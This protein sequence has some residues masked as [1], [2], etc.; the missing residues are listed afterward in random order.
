M[1]IINQ[2]FRT[3][4]SYLQED[5]YYI[6]EYQREYSWEKSEIEDF[7]IDLIHLYD[8]NITDHFLGQIVIHLDKEEKRKYLIDGQQR[9]ATLTIMLSVFREMFSEIYEKYGIEDAKIDADDITTQYIGR[10]TSRRNELK[11][12]LGESDKR[13]FEKFIQ[14]TEKYDD[15]TN[16]QLTKSEKRVHDAYS[17]FTKYLEQYIENITNAEQRYEVLNNLFHTLIKGFKIMYVE[18]DELN[19]AFIIFETLNAR[20]K[21][22]ETADLLK[23]NVLR[24]AGKKLPEVQSSWYKM[25]D[26]L[27]KIDATRFIRHYWNANHKFVREKDLYKSIRNQITSPKDS[28]DLVEDLERLS[29]I[30][31]AFDN[32]NEEIYFEDN[33]LNEKLKDVK[34]LGG[35]TYYPIFLAM[36]KENYSEKDILT[37]LSLVEKL[38]VRN[39]VVAGRVSNKYETEF[40]TIA[41]KISHHTLTNVNEIEKALKNLVITNEE[42]KSSFKTFTVKKKGVIR[43]LLR[44]LNKLNNKE[45]DIIRDNNTIHI[46]H[47]MPQKPTHWNV[48]QE[49][50]EQNLNKLG[51]LTLLGDEYNKNCTNS[52]FD[53]KKDIYEQSNI[54]ITKDLTIYEDWGEYQIRNRQKDLTDKA[55]KI[56]RT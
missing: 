26:N 9:T 40:S 53:V 30:Y 35:I 37:I 52:T 25:L 24:V 46:E 28:L 51:N 33:Q 5:T 3:V 18:T 16:K 11:V 10:I 19:E 54:D 1:G 43:Y 27:G 7:W 14:R 31:S 34:L 21:D 22:L 45:T 4:S 6:P 13:F 42:F 2:S 15:F 17:Y 48:S 29:V 12:V 47:I 32:P 23:N 36:A 55:V 49:V 20:G 39:F 50:H 56:W 44:S 8:S 38:I 41:N